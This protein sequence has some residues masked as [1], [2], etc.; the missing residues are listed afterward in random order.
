MHAPAGGRSSGG[1]RNR[2]L[3]REERQATQGTSPW[4]AAP[5]SLPAS[6]TKATPAMNDAGCI[7]L[8]E[9]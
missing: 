2:A 6:V 7:Q 8:T 1:R 4:R 5:S 9:R 3:L